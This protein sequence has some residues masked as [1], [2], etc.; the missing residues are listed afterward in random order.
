[1]KYIYDALDILINISTESQKRVLLDKFISISPLSFA[2]EFCTIKLGA[3]RASGHTYSVVRL[4]QERKMKIAYFSFSKI[5]CKIFNNLVLF[6]NVKD[7]LKLNYNFRE[8]MDSL[9]GKTFDIDAIIVDNSFNLSNSQEDM[10]YQFGAIYSNP[11]CR[12]SGSPYF[13]YIFLQ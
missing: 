3:S 11:R 2:K 4:M 9:L 5:T 10:I 8:N 13:Y 6:S 1:M 7:N 12:F